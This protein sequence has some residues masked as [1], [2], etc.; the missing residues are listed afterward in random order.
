VRLRVSESEGD[1]VVKLR[2]EAVLTSTGLHCFHGEPL[3]ELLECM[4]RLKISLWV[5]RLFNSLHTRN[6]RVSYFAR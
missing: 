1:P 2:W 3:G 5:G 6:A 4:M